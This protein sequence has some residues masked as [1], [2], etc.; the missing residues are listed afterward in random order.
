[1]G[2][3]LPKKPRA[4]HARKKKG[5]D[6]DPYGKFLNVRVNGKYIPKSVEDSPFALTDEKLKKIKEPKK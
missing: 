4:R 5:G 6:P 1:M 2:K 3:K